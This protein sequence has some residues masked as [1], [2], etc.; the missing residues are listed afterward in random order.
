MLQQHKNQSKGAIN[1][2]SNLR[3]TQG[4]WPRA[5]LLC[6]VTS[7]S[8]QGIHVV[9]NLKVLNIFNIGY[10]HFQTNS[11]SYNT[12]VHIQLTLNMPANI[13]SLHHSSKN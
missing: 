3:L 6:L 2:N 1:M 10:L 4:I 8:R 9:V 12:G 5:A 11:I 7:F 13:Q